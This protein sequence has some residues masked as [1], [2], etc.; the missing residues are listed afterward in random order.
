M[1]QKI[2]IVDDDNLIASSLADELTEAGFDVER[3]EDGE[4]GL[5]KAEDF[6]PDLI[7]LDLVMPK[8][9]GFSVLDELKKKEGLKSI[10]VMI[11]TVS[12]NEDQLEHALSAGAVDALI[13]SK[14][15]LGG[16]AE[17]VKSVISK[18]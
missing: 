1:S 14:Y 11:M 17:R 9:N 13:K 8:V 16:I 10:P 7:L 3:A 2:L 18:P 15:T 12:A 6:Q 5:Q 4:V